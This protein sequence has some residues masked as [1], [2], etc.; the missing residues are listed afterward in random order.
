M[1]ALGVKP[2]DI[3]AYNAAIAGLKEYVSTLKTAFRIREKGDPPKWADAP[4][5][6]KERVLASD[7]EKTAFVR[8]LVLD[9]WLSERIV[10]HLDR[11][12]QDFL[13]SWE[14][15]EHL[16][17][18]MPELVDSVC[19]EPIY[20]SFEKRG[21]AYGYFCAKTFIP[22]PAASPK[23][24]A[25]FLLAVQ[26]EGTCAHM[27]Q[28]TLVNPAQ[29]LSEESATWEERDYPESAEDFRLLIRALA[30]FA[31]VKNTIDVRTVLTP[32][33]TKPYLDVRVS[34]LA[35]K[36]KPALQYPCGLLST[37]FNFPAGYLSN[38]RMIQDYEKE[39]A[40]FEKP[41]M[42]ILDITNG[43]ELHCNVETV[44]LLQRRAILE[45]DSSR[46]VFRYTRKVGLAVA[47][48]REKMMAEDGFRADIF[49]YMPYDVFALA[50]D[51]IGYYALVQ[52]V[53][54]RQ[55]D[56]SMYNGVL[57]HGMHNRH[58]VWTA[59]PFFGMP[60]FFQIT[61]ERDDV[62]NTFQPYH[63]PILFH[64]LSVL[65]AKDTKKG[66][67]AQKGVSAR[68]NAPAVPV[69]PDT[70]AVPPIRQGEDIPLWSMHEVTARTVKR[71]VHREHNA[72]GWKMPPH[73]RRAH[74]HS[75][76]VGKGEN[77]HLERRLLEPVRVNPDSIGTL[78]P[79]VH[80][81][82]I[83]SPEKTAD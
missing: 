9:R 68:V 82:A 58:I 4:A 57:L 71:S 56:G 75:Y 36:C 51:D 40:E 66:E 7:V 61:D 83:C 48:K 43:N 12:V 77:R 15:I 31:L 41:D 64:I 18:V 46:I 3:K 34:P 16:P 5:S 38:E 65:E 17:M 2:S 55:N 25:L 11:E 52:K 8:D 19:S 79:T 54:F 42:D 37:G 23:Q 24:N 78:R 10:F 13:E 21:K 59:V 49:Q 70:T 62:E 35:E 80:N 53:K 73:I 39:L 44:K 67:R 81:I 27:I 76:W 14:E 60:T 29:F 47:D 74:Y 32:D 45:W 50:L 26:K 72:C 22:D 69:S 20:V 33:E 6:I 1:L 30:Y 63:I 28:S